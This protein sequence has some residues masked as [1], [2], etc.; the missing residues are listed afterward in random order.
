M[1][2]NLKSIYLGAHD[3]L[4]ALPVQRRLAAVAAQEPV[5]QRDLGMICLQSDRPGEAID[6]FQAYL[7]ARPDAEDAETVAA[8]LK[9]ARRVVAE[10]N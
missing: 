9:T 8:L 10:W 1:L 2:R 7:T 3:Y 6:P 5:E 4:S